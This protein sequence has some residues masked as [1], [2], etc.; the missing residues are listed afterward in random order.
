MCFWLATHSYV[1]CV[2]DWSHIMLCDVFLSGYTLLCVICIGLVTHHYV[3]CLGL[4]MQQPLQ[5][6]P[7]GHPGGL[8]MLWSAG[9]IADGQCQRMD[10]PAC[11]RTPQNGLLQKSLEEDLC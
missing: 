1:C 11:A 10:I 5:N 2:F 6:H 4:V 9:A 3:H 8:A 7:S